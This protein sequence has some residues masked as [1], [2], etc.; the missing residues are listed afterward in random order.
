MLERLR[1][2]QKRKRLLAVAGII[3]VVFILVNALTAFAYRGRTYPHTKVLGVEVG[4]KLYPEAKSTVRRADPLPHSLDLTYKNQKTTIRPADLGVYLDVD[5]LPDVAAQGRS[6]LP[7]VNLVMHHTLM[8]P[9]RLDQTVY[10]SG[11]ASLA[12]TFHQDPIPAHIVHNGSKN[13]FEVAQSAPGYQLDTIALQQVLVN[14]IT[15]GKNVTV[16][17]NT[18]PPSS[19]IADPAK[20]LQAVR[21]QLDTS[22]TYSFNDKSVKAGAADIA[23]WYTQSGNDLVVSPDAV[24]AYITQV[25]KRMG[26]AP[27][28]IDQAVNNTVDAL[29]ASRDSTIKLFNHVKGYTYCLAFRGVPAS[30]YTELAKRTATAYA[31]GRGWSLEGQ[32]VFKLVNS[33]CDFTVWLTAAD[34]MPS[35]GAICDS[36]W[37]CTINNNVII[38]F[39][40]WQNATTSW[41]AAH[42]GSIDDYR[43]MAINHETGHQLGFEHSTCT[44]PGKPAPV[45]EQQSIDLQG[46]TFNI[47]PLASEQNMLRTRLGL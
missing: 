10:R 18:V 4:N 24:R 35:F 16:P 44:T 20:A 37:S 26:A 12:T 32:V 40:R 33:G 43:L 19:S 38:N 41:N 46:C 1:Q 14:A 21:H 25:G 15:P 22:F 17:V 8:P 29:Q 27:Q 5:K 23:G 11:T 28:N 34:Q 7:L 39:D 9:V 45:M 30:N 13:T 31:D 2:L 6:W 3:L 47:W 36:V 42:A